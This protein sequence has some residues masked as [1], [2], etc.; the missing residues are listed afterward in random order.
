M[1]IGDRSSLVSK[2]FMDF[3]KT[4]W[5]NSGKKI[6]RQKCMKNA[7]N[8]ARQMPATFLDVSATKKNLFTEKQT[9]EESLRLGKVVKNL[10]IS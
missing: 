3:L 7:N 5:P 4:V 2:E 10:E 8:V 9:F 6:E 1:T